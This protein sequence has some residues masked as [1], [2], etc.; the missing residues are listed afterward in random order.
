MA[1]TFKKEVSFSGN[2]S[3]LYD[4]GILYLSG[5]EP[6]PRSGFLYADDAALHPRAQ[7]HDLS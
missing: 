1:V 4:V 2:D 5:A 3:A 6:L 7:T